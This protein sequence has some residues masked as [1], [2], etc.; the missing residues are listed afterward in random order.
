MEIRDTNNGVID[1]MVIDSKDEACKSYIGQTF[2]VLSDYF[3]L[4]E[5]VENLPTFEGIKDSLY[6]R[7]TES[8]MHHLWDVYENG[9]LKVGDEIVAYFDFVNTIE[10]IYENQITLTGAEDVEDLVA[11]WEIVRKKYHDKYIK[12]GGT[13]YEEEKEAI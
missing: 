9:K 6:G 3:N 2:D 8:V 7:L 4:I 11:P 13:Y 12:D 5:K 1:V 10:A